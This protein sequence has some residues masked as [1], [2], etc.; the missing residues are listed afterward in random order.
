MYAYA[1]ICS[2]G[3]LMSLDTVAIVLSN[4]AMDHG[5]K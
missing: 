5:S 2:R 4:K 3:V 1:Y